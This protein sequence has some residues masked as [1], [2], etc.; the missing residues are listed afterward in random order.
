MVGALLKS[1]LTV[2]LK[3]SP[4][5]NGMNVSYGGWMVIIALL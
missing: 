4:I 5:I 1:L 2:S 3:W